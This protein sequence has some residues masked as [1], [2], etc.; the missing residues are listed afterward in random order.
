MS[1]T[2]GFVSHLLTYAPPLFLAPLKL[3]IVCL[4]GMLP[5]SKGSY[6]PSATYG[7]EVQH[8]PVFAMYAG[9]MHGQLM[10]LRELFGALRTAVTFIALVNPPYV[11]HEGLLVRVGPRAQLAREQVFGMFVVLGH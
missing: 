9:Q 2:Q 5:Q 7:A 4:T 3:P 1:G 10:F 8:F 6:E 11:L